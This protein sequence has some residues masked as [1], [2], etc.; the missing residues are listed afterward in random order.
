[1]PKIWRF[2]L[3]TAVLVNFLKAKKYPEILKENLWEFAWGQGW[4][5]IN[6]RPM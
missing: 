1:M 3:K 2:K 6:G 5:G 4:K